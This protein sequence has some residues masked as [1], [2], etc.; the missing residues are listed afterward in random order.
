MIAQEWHYECDA[1]H[2]GEPVACNTHIRRLI[3]ET[4]AHQSPILAYQSHP[5]VPGDKNFREPLATGHFP[6]L[7]GRSPVRSRKVRPARIFNT[8]DSLS[9]PH[10][11]SVKENESP[12]IPRSETSPQLLRRLEYRFVR[13][14]VYQTVKMFGR[15]CLRR[16]HW[17]G[18]VRNL[19]LRRNGIYLL[20]ANGEQSLAPSIC[21]RRN[22]RFP[23]ECRRI[24]CAITTE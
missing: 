22:L 16:F 17:M 18:L 11:K 7:R 21:P 14:A 12:Q 20:T 4:A 3:D 13:L 19:L 2:L 10:R 5:L 1:I 24:V 8:N 15:N 6:I 9:P 23:W